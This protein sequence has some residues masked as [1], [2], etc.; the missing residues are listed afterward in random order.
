MSPIPSPLG[1]VASGLFALGA[2]RSLS[3]LR[4]SFEPQAASRDRRR[5]ERAKRPGVDVAGSL[6]PGSCGIRAAG[7]LSCLGGNSFGNLGLGDTTQRLV[8]TQVEAG[9]PDRVW[10]QV[11][12]LSASAAPCCV[13]A[14]TTRGSLA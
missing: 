5:R 1:K 7:E 3:L 4:V 2:R 14:K 13:P 10:Q 11:A 8:P 12:V 6:R 9:K